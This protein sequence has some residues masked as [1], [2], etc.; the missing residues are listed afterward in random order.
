MS[1]A[2]FRT[3][4]SARVDGEALPPE[5]PEGALDAHLRV[6]PE[7]RG[8]GERAR[9]LRELAARIDDARF[10]GARLEVRFDRE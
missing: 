10:D 2:A 8:W 3:A 9:E 6:C 7:C 1:C 4:L 5:M